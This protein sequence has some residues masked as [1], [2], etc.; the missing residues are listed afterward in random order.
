[1]SLRVLTYLKYTGDYSHIIPAPLLA[2]I[3]PR[4]KSGIDINSLKFTIISSHF[5]EELCKKKKTKNKNK[6]LTTNLVIVAGFA[7]L[8]RG[9]FMGVHGLPV[10]LYFAG[11]RFDFQLLWRVISAVSTLS[12]VSIHLWLYYMR[13]SAD[14]LATQLAKVLRF[15]PQNVLGH[16]VGRA[17]FG[18]QLVNEA[19]NYRV[20]AAESMKVLAYKYYNGLTAKLREELEWLVHQNSEYRGHLL[21]AYLAQIR[22]PGDLPPML[23]GGLY[24]IKS[25]PELSYL[26]LS[27][28]PNLDL[29]FDSPEPIVIAAI[30]QYAARNIDALAEKFHQSIVASPTNAAGASHLDYIVAALFLDVS[31]R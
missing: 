25:P 28:T 1:M 21:N 17:R 27:R 18:F 22:H 14:E 2:L 4:P 24:Q 12:P 23:R 8:L 16:L 19:Y 11:T 7:S 20:N 26:F 29:Q 31:N 30:E 5:P 15:V 6:N 10:S 3:G 13:Y 9:L